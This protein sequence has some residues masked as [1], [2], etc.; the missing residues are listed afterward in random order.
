MRGHAHVQAWRRLARLPH[1][2]NDTTVSAATAAAA[3]A[4]LASA[5]DSTRISRLSLLERSAAGN[6]GNLGKQVAAAASTW[7]PRSV[8]VACGAVRLRWRRRRHR[9]WWR[10]RRRRHSLLPLRR[11][12]RRRW[13]HRGRHLSLRSGRR[14]LRW[15]RSRSRRHRQSLRRR[16]GRWGLGRRSRRRRWLRAR[17]RFLLLQSLPHQQKGGG[18]DAHASRAAVRIGAEFHQQ[19]VSQTV[20]CLGLSV[21]ELR[22]EQIRHV[23]LCQEPVGIV[24]VLLKGQLDRI[25]WSARSQT[26]GQRGCGC[27]A[28]RVAER[29]DRHETAPPGRRGLEQPAGV[30]Q[31]SR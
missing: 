22:D 4:D 14:S 26:G 5:S 20:S 25:V 1:A 27:D 18:V 8:A 16:R 10:A 24:I 12:Q 2:V 19:P 11:W 28:G 6:S 31:S 13:R 15:R 3:A 23:L 21:A 7:R 29:V 17:R 9:L 30:R